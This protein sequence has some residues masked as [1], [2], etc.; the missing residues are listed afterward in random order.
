MPSN[1]N[2]CHEDSKNSWEREQIEWQFTCRNLQDEISKWGMYSFQ[3]KQNIDAVTGGGKGLVTV[4]EILKIQDGFRTRF[5]V[6][7]V[8]FKCGQWLESYGPCKWF[9][10]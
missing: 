1:Y 7:I 9:W 10:K 4:K 3:R 5:H 8:T 2:E 6:Q